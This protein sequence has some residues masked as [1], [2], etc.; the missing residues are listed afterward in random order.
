MARVFDPGLRL[1]FQFEIL[2]FSLFSIVLQSARLRFLG[3]LSVGPATDVGEEVPS[4][5]LLVGPAAISVHW[6]YELPSPGHVSSTPLTQ[7]R[8]EQHPLL[9]FEQSPQ[10]ARHSCLSCIQRPPPP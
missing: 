8:G 3:S 2:F 5:V 1:L 6:Q 7:L 4:F 10:R 9:S